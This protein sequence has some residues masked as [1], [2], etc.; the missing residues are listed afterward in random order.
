MDE[1]EIHDNVRRWQQGDSGGWQSVAQ[2][3]WE[4]LHQSMTKEVQFHRPTHN[5]ND[6]VDAAFWRAYERLDLNLNPVSRLCEKTGE[7]K[8]KTKKKKKPDGTLVN[9]PLFR[10]TVSGSESLTADAPFTWQ[11]TDRFKA[12]F[13]KVWSAN[14][15]DVIRAATPHRM[16]VGEKPNQLTGALDP[17]K[18][19]TPIPHATITSLT[20]DDP[21]QST[22]V[23]EEQL[24]GNELDPEMHLMH[25]EEGSVVEAYIFALAQVAEQLRERSPKEAAIAKALLTYVKNEV[26]RWQSS[27]DRGNLEALVFDE[28]SAWKSVQEQI[29]PEGEEYF[30]T[31]KQRFFEKVSALPDVPEILQVGVRLQ[32]RTDLSH[33]VLDGRAAAPRL[34]SAHH[35]AAA[36]VLT[37]V[38]DYARVSFAR[39]YPRT[40]Q[41][42]YERILTVEAEG[43]EEITYI[44]KMFHVNAPEELKP[45]ALTYADLCHFV[46]AAFPM[47]AH[48]LAVLPTVGT[49]LK[50]L[51][52]KPQRLFS[53]LD[54]VRPEHGI[55]TR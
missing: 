7:T 23:S 13:R 19:R 6:V 33:W 8:T 50:T 40:A 21:D 11:G 9:L 14:C 37:L 43:T 2:W 28:T 20:V 34:R 35:A 26:A 3:L 12:W 5:L 41:R 44:Q 25:L 53:L 1:H 4:S 38:T 42:S 30:S 16:V 32:W 10:G 22:D 51:N 45:R 31:Y 54:L 18:D 24:G 15:R 36:S 48:L 39:A 52:P 47:S 46:D 27:P 55:N 49:A 17:I 29:Y